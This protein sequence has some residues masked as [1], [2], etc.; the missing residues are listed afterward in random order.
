M[1]HPF[2]A[3]LS[4]SAVLTV[5]LAQSA[6]A[7]GLDV[8]AR[9]DAGATV[10]HLLA[11]G[12]RFQLDVLDVWLDAGADVNAL[13]AGRTPLML[14][15][16][17]DDPKRP[18]LVTE[19]LGFMDRLIERGARVIEPTQPLDD[20]TGTLRY[21]SVP[22]EM[23]RR[24][25]EA[26]ASLNSRDL[27]G[28]TP[29]H[30][31]VSLRA[32]DKVR[33]LLEHGADASAIDAWGLTPLAFARRTR[34]E[35]WVAH[36]GLTAAFDESIAALVAHGAP[37]S[38]LPP[39]DGS[40]PTPRAV[41]IEALHLVA[42]ARPIASAQ[43]LVDGVRHAGEPEKAIELARALA[44]CMGEPRTLKIEGDLDTLQRRPFFWHGD[45][46]VSGN[47]DWSGRAIVTGNVRVGGIVT[48]AGHDSCVTIGGSLECRA[49]STS[50]DFAVGAALVASELV[51][52]FHNDCL[53]HA[54]QIEAPVVIEDDHA[55]SARV[56]SPHHFD[57]DR[58]PRGEGV[59]EELEALFVPETLNDG[60]LDND[61]AFTRL[62]N[63]LPVLR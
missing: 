41:P 52:G 49:L 29:L 6:L 27:R 17:Q 10:L 34:E 46:E 62:R 11:T 37:E 19:L 12:P 26:G 45:L 35:R 4:D 55:V 25:L 30:S 48:D 31:A 38:A 54:E 16:R 36:N 1:A 57:I 3:T 21:A 56:V 40:W 9:N 14:V 58:Y 63:G 23:Y 61:Q 2:F 51:L 32:P 18:Q 5:D 60:Q 33:L 28:R 20:V 15:P 47:L 7:G 53:L 24:L 50:G 8:N 43:D 22:F 44:A 42:L 13:F 59:A 39:W